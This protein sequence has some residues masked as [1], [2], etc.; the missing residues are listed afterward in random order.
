MRSNEANHETLEEAVR[1]LPSYAPPPEVWANIEQALEIMTL[2]RPLHEA[3]GQLPAYRPPAHLWAAIEAGLAA[4][5]AHRPGRM[6]AL[7]WASAAA[8]ATVLLLTAYFLVPTPDSQLKLSYIRETADAPA[9]GLYHNDWDADEASLQQ[10]AEQ[11]SKDPV[12]K[13][14]PEYSSILAEWQD[15]NDAKAEVVSFMERYG[16]DG[17]IIRQLAEIERERSALARQMAIQI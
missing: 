5:P 16:K 12:A 15:L 17:Q 8:A 2:E 13:Q 11:Y 9:Q 7:R 6:R 3:I 10:L 4:E 14:Q 1:Q